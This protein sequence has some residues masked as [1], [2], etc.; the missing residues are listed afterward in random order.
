MISLMKEG[1]DPLTDE[2]IEKVAV[3]LVLHVLAVLTD[4]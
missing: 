2:E 4:L 1:D 3:D